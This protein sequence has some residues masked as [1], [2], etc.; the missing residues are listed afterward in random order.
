MI[1]H[2]YL[3]SCCDGSRQLRAFGDDARQLSSAMIPSTKIDILRS[4]LIRGSATAAC[5]RDRPTQAQEGRK[6]GYL[7]RR[8]KQEEALARSLAPDEWQV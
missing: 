3:S 6:E 7:L 1:A 5:F 2:H 4:N 8:R